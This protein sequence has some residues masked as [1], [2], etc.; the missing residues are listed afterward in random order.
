MFWGKSPY[1]INIF[2]IQILK[3]YQNYYEFKK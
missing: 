1:S 3:K 2:G